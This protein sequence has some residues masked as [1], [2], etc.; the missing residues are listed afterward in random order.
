[1]NSQPGAK[2]N[3]TMELTKMSTAYIYRY[4]FHMLV[5][6]NGEIVNALYHGVNRSAKEKSKF[7]T[8]KLMISTVID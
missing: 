8:N 6:S 7:L 1:M 3:Q 5:I 4:R 2:E